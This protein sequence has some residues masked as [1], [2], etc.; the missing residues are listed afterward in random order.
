MVI[1]GTFRT[2]IG[3]ANKISYQYIF[4]YIRYILFFY[5]LCVNTVSYKR[6]S[7][8]GWY[9]DEKSKYQ[10]RDRDA[11]E[12]SWSFTNAKKIMNRLCKY[13]FLVFIDFIGRLESGREE[14]A[15]Q[16]WINHNI[17]KTKETIK[18]I[19]L[20][21]KSRHHWRLDYRWVI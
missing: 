20:C 16:L 2:D 13:F 4:F 9:E 18:N 6:A 5:L 8:D 17:I 3:L 10:F 15:D 21:R 7:L 1:E 11:V 19:I 12:F 14:C